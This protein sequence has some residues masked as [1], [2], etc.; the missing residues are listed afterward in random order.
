VLSD[1]AIETEGVDATDLSGQYDQ[2]QRQASIEEDKELAAIEAT[3]P[4]NL[5]MDVVTNPCPK[6]YHKMIL[7][8]RPIDLRKLEK[9]VVFGMSPKSTVTTLRY[10]EVKAYEDA[11]GY[12]RQGTVTRGKKGSM[13]KMI[14]IIGLCVVGLVIGLLF[15]MKGPELM[16]M[17]GLG[18]TM[19]IWAGKS[20]WKK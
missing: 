1:D 13:G 2:T 8:G 10:N 9:Y 3:N 19:T 17:F 14:L 15:L 16:K 6:G 18:G 20:L 5:F 4:H 11:Q 12:G 7:M